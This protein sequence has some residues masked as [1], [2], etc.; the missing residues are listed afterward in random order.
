MIILRD[1]I[2]T[3]RRDYICDA[4]RIFSNSNYE[5]NDLS[6]EDWQTVIAAKNDKDRIKRGSKYRKTVYVDDGF[7]TY[8]ARI[9]M[10]NILQKYELFE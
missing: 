3:A 7:C 1:E 4:C 10:D 5:E 9:D 2:R 6:P 8:R